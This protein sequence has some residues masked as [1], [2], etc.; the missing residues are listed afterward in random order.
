[1]AKNLNKLTKDELGRL[2]PV[3]L[4][5]YNPDWP[6]LFVREKKRIIALLGEQV[7]LKVEHIGSTSVVGLLTKPTIDILVEIPKGEQIKEEII[8]TMISHG[9][10]Y[11]HDQTDHIMVVKGYTPDGFKGQCY[12]IHMGPDDHTGLWDRIYFR[13]YLKTHPS[14]AREYALLK[15]D[16]ADKYQF[17]REAYTDSKSEFVAEI[18]RVAKDSLK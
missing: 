15:K 6:E 18:T 11:M 9:Y 4:A 2:F 14:V 12:H 3:I 13:D 16:L 8:S 10:N 7:A 1:M 17:D 5:E